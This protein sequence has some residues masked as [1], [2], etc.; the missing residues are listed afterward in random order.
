MKNTKKEKKVLSYDQDQRAFLAH[1]R[2]V[3]PNFTEVLQA[4][5]RAKDY[6]EKNTDDPA[7]KKNAGRASGNQV[8]LQ[9]LKKIGAEK[10]RNVK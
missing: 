2:A 1:C 3:L 6:Y 10:W 9:E 7:R 8:F 5:I 4:A